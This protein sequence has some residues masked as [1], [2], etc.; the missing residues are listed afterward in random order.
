MYWICNRFQ[1]II[2]VVSKFDPKWSRHE[3]KMLILKFQWSKNPKSVFRFNLSSPKV[4]PKWSRSDFAKSE[5]KNHASKNDVSKYS[6]PHPK[7]KCFKISHT[8]SKMYGKVTFKMTCWLKHLA[9][10]GGPQRI[11]N[12]N[13]SNCKIKNGQMLSNYSLH[14]RA[15]SN[16]YKIGF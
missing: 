7:Y 16:V 8:R 5:Q 2:R 4:V 14:A 12:F 1:K 13:R 15:N 11:S 10:F 6:A 3:S 9:L